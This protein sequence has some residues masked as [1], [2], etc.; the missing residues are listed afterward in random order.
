MV[1]NL[2]KKKKEA[3]ELNIYSPMNGEVV[4]L[5]NVPDP[6]FSQKMMGEGIAILPTE[7]KVYAPF[8]GKVIHVI[9]SKHAIGLLAADGTELLIHIGIETVNLKGEGFTVHVEQDQSVT[10]GDLLIE[11][12]LAFVKEKADSL[13]TPII[14][15]NSQGSDKTFTMTEEKSARQGETVLMTVSE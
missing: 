14:I 3:K 6:V 9:H 4:Q 5:K 15:T 1:F 10:K 11:F 13:V 7:G 8:D 2:F 12:D